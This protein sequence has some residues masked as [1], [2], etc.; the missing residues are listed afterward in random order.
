MAPGWLPTD[1]PPM[2]TFAR[3]ATPD[4][5]VVAVPALLPSTVKVIDLPLIAEPSL[6]FFSVAE[7]FAVPPTVAD[8]GLTVRVVAARLLTGS[9]VLPTVERCLVSPP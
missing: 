9:V 2:L 6:V 3:V 5:F 1:A 8:A 4:A 7:R